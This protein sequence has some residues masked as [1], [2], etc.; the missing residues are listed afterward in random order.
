MSWVLVY[1]LRVITWLV[2]I[3]ILDYEIV[4]DCM[5]NHIHSSLPFLLFCV[6]CVVFSFCDDHQFIDGSR[7]E[8]SP[9]SSG[10]WRFCCIAIWAGF[11]S[12]E[13]S[14]CDDHQFIDGSRC[15]NSPWSSRWWRFRCIAIWA[16]FHSS[17]FLLGLWPMYFLVIGLYFEILSI[18]YDTLLL[19]SWCAL[20]LFLF[21]FGQL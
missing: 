15:G 12:S 21:S 19:A 4:S 11:R 2:D 5:I 3:C 7:C 17:E 10:W 6:M 20:G 8:N 1:C 13:F 14:F 16:R 18:C 9:W